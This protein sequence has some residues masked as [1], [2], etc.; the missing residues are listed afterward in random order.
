MIVAALS[1]LGTIATEREFH[2]THAF[3]RTMQ[4]ITAF[5]LFASGNGPNITQDTRNQFT[6]YLDVFIELVHVVHATR[7]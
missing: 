6:E 3:I 4:T 1:A 5:A 2:L 7:V